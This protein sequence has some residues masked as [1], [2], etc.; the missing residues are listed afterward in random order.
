[1]SILEVGLVFQSFTWYSFLLQVIIDDAGMCLEPECMI[2]IICSGAQQVVLVGDEK[3]VSAWPR[4]DTV[5]RD[6]HPLKR[7]LLHRYATRAQVI[8]NCQYRM[9]TALRFFTLL[10]GERSEL[11][12]DQ[13]SKCPL[14]FMQV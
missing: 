4:D 7:S 9:V 11:T 6:D 1:M 3:E 13:N 8:L 12:T 5:Q 14:L 10:Q 2:P